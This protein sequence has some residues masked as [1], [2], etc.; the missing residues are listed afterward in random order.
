MSKKKKSFS[1]RN[2]NVKR[3][4]N[5]ATIF[6]EKIWQILQKKEPCDFVLRSG[7]YD[8]LDDVVFKVA[9]FYRMHL[10]K[11]VKNNKVI[12]IDLKTRKPIIYSKQIKE[13][14]IDVSHNILDFKIGKKDKIFNII[15]NIDSYS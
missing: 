12:F 7:K 11:I 3:D 2:I 10:K 15:K 9:Q 1:I 5:L 14:S 8:Y 4:W 13:K 6:I